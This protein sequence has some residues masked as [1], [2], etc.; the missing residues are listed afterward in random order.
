[1]VIYKVDAFSNG[2]FT[3]NPAGVVILK[4]RWP[5]EKLMQNIAFEN[6]LAETAFVLFKEDQ[7]RIRWFTPA[8]EVELCGHATLAS[9]H[10]LFSHEGYDGHEICFKSPSG[11]LFVRRTGEMLTLNFPTDIIAELHITEDMVK[12]FHLRPLQAW[13]GKTDL[14]L[15]FD[16]E[17]QIRDLVPSFEAIMNLNGRGI[18]ATAAGEQVDFVSRFFAPQAG[19]PEDPVTGSAHTTLTPYWS[20]RLGKTEMTAMQLSKRTGWLFCKDMGERTEISGRAVT[21]LAGE[22]MIEPA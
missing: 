18:I 14:M 10:V 20:S 9:A 1:M 19:V 11:D 15:V 8:V 6:N 13:K 22:I 21:Y 2:L 16:N 7:W 3:G 17:K 4:D 12:C 5:D